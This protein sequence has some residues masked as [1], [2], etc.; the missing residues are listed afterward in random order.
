MTML[1]QDPETG[2]WYDDGIEEDIGYPPPRPPDSLLGG[3]YV[4]PR[5]GVRTSKGIIA[6]ALLDAE[7]ARK[8]P[9]A[10]VQL[11]GDDTYDR[12]PISSGEAIGYGNRMIVRRPGE[13]GFTT[14]GGNEPMSDYFKSGGYRGRPD[15][16]HADSDV[17]YYPDEVHTKNKEGKWDISQ[18]NL[19]KKPPTVDELSS[20]KEVQEFKSFYAE[21]VKAKATAAAEEAIA[22]RKK[23][24]SITT[25]ALLKPEVLA[26]RD[27]ADASAYQ[28]VLQHNI[29]KGMT[30]L[31]RYVDQTF[32]R[33]VEEKK[34]KRE[35]VEA[36]ARYN[37]ALEDRR[38]DAAVKVT[39][40]AEK[41]AF[42]LSE[43]EAKTS[44]VK[45]AD[46]KWLTKTL[47]ELNVKLKDDGTE[48]DQNTMKAL[49]DIAKKNGKK[50]EKWYGKKAGSLFGWEGD[51]YPYMAL[52]DED[53]KAQSGG[54]TTKKQIGT[55]NGKPVYDLGN[56]KWQ[57]GD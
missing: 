8:S 13:E 15:D 48:P 33:L 5:E 23:N 14:L 16:S 31:D 49:N 57:V 6:K 10:R 3:S 1:V 17:I 45:S 21:D 43:R 40:K 47:D 53:K 27:T 7:A 19:P 39:E 22:L 56:G 50:I 26:A 37:R 9:Q 34:N 32:S 41:D 12:T 18:R 28:S 2:E 52:V 30:G 4:G 46:M 54:N 55:K 24:R 51:K 36:T 38:K 20:F 11:L 44:E 29:D 42:A 35:E 25:D